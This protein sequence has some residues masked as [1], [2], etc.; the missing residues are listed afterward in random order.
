M[1]PLAP[2]M[3]PDA[4]LED[5]VIQA[6]DRRAG[7]APEMLQGLVLLEEFSG[8]E[9][10]DAADERRD[11]DTLARRRE[12]PE[13]SDP[14]LEEDARAVVVAVAPVMEADTDLQDPV[15]EAADRRAGVTPQRLEGLVLFEEL[16]GVELLDAADER[17]WRWIGAP[18]TDAFVDCAAG[19]A[20]RRPSR[21]AIAASGLG[22]VRRRAISGS[23]ARPR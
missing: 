11:I 23:E 17:G 19:N 18:G 15:I 7:V 1:V 4:D 16:A 6:A 8:V 2:V 12:R 14:F 9:L 20:L 3:E 13:S 22:W 10:L 5:A 21:L